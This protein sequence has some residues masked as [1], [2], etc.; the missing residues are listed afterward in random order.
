[1][2]KAC[3]V[4]EHDGKM[5]VNIERVMG[6]MG[7]RQRRSEVGVLLLGR[8]W[9]GSNRIEDHDGRII[10]HPRNAGNTEHTIEGLGARSPRRTSRRSEW[11]MRLSTLCQGSLHTSTAILGTIQIIVVLG[12]IERIDGRQ[13]LFRGQDLV[14]VGVEARAS[15]LAWQ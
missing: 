15:G 1:M 11:T 8:S 4:E 12:S 7:T 5:R 10:R 9:I 3:D 2:H 13:A 6:K 14:A